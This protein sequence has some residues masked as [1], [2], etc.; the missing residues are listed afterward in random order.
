MAKCR[1]LWDGSVAFYGDCI[2]SRACHNEV[3]VLWSIE[4]FSSDDPPPPQSAAPT[5]YDPSRLTRS[6]FSPSMTPAGPVLY[7][8]IMELDT[9][10]CGPQFFMRFRLHH[11]SGQNPV[12]AFCNANGK[13]FFWDFER[14]RGFRN[15]VRAATDAQ[16]TGQP[17]PARP[18]WLQAAHPRKGGEQSGKGTASRDARA[19][20][21]VASSDVGV[22]VKDH[23]E[24]PLKG[25]TRETVSQWESKY[26]VDSARQ[27]LKAHRVE[28]FGTSNF[29]GRQVG[30]SP[31]GEW[32]V[33][34]GSSNVA[35]MLQRWTRK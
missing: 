8:R 5:P 29:V 18:S 20:T 27:P 4:G 33:V 24:G 30:W 13:V 22:G 14:L 6:A 7:S 28:A 10:G 2:L 1:A 17:V 12:L 15:F 32:C 19:S 35:L 31:G 23:A 21:D 3:I 11:A 9:P 26:D 34:V 25:Y 16:Q